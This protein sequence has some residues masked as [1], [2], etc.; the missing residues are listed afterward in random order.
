VPLSEVYF[1]PYFAL[2][3]VAL[4]VGSKLVTD[5]RWFTVRRN[6]TLSALALFLAL[7][8]VGPLL[9]P[10]YV[11]IDPDVRAMSTSAGQ[12]DVET[13]SADLLAFF[14]PNNGNPFYTRLTWD[15]YT[16]MNSGGVP[17]EAVFLGY[18]TLLLGL[19]AFAFRRNRNPTTL[20]WLLVAVTGF[21]LALGPTLYVAGHAVM[22]L[23]TYNVV[24]GC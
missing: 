4:F 19:G 1:L 23:P 24:F 6:V 5:W 20:L 2:P 3:F 13:Y 12:R 8:I 16:K 18:P 7:A 15:V 22:P 17:E 21:V 14:L 11:R 10:G 9:A